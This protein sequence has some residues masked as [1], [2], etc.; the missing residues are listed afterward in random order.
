MHSQRCSSHYG[1]Q[2]RKMIMRDSVTG[3]CP[4]TR[5]FINIQIEKLTFFWLLHLNKPPA[6]THS[7]RQTPKYV[8]VAVNHRIKTLIITM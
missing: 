8:K 4:K 2:G 3:S 6:A 7:S 1:H 5:L